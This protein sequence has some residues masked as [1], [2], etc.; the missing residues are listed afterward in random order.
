MTSRYCGLKP[1]AWKN[2]VQRFSSPAMNALSAVGSASCASSACSR[3]RE[4]SC[5][6]IHTECAP[7]SISASLSASACA[8]VAALMSVLTLGALPMVW[9]GGRRVDSWTAGRKVAFTFTALL[10]V[11]LSVLLGL[12]G[13]LLPSS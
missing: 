8:L 7:C 2:A 12:W 13:Y 1:D 6:S 10:F 9:R 4:R 3:L 11:L 5:A